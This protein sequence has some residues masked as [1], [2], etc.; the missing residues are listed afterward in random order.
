MRRALG[1]ATSERCS[2]HARL[3]R[4]AVHLQ[5]QQHLRLL[6]AWAVAAVQGQTRGSLACGSQHHQHL[7]RAWQL[8]RRLQCLLPAQRRLLRHYHV[9]LAR[10]AW[11]RLLQLH[12]VLLVVA[13]ATMSRSTTMI[14]MLLRLQMA[15]ARARTS[16][17]A[18][19]VVTA[20]ALATL[21]LHTALNRLLQPAPLVVLPV[22]AALVGLHQLLLRQ[23]VAV[24]M[25]LS[26]SAS[27]YRRRR[28]QRKCPCAILP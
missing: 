4:T 28:K 21:Q 7:R 5:R 2:R 8:L 22:G 25:S 17:V 13:A 1:R 20:A 23:Q 24:M 27:M 11:Q 9:A 19:A 10:V 16:G 14:G 18:L 15:R 6:Q 26:T 12:Q 3:A